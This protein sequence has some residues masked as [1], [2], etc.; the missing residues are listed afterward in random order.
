MAIKHAVHGEV[1]DLYSFH[2]KSTAA[3]IK[4]GEFEV[5]RLVV[6]A[7]NPI[8]DHKVDGPITVQCISGQCTFFVEGE[9]RELKPGAW[10]HLTGGTTHSLEAQEKTVL[11]L[12]ILL[13]ESNKDR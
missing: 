6:E 10:L 3:L 1:I 5:I 9:P 4:S 12:T 13:C 2:T 11:I 8:P 7:G